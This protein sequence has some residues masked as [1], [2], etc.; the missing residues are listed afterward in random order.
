MARAAKRKPRG[1][2]ALK[3]LSEALREKN[4]IKRK[5]KLTVATPGTTFRPT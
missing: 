5:V 4:L 2:N 1:A 3:Q